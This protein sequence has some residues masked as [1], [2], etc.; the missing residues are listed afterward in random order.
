MRHRMRKMSI[1]ILLAVVMI[2]GAVSDSATLLAKKAEPSEYDKWDGYS[3]MGPIYPFS[4]AIFILSH[5]LERWSN[6]RIRLESV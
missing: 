6:G 4:E 5:R 3:P 1:G 2:C